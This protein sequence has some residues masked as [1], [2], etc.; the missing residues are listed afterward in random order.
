MR[1]VTHSAALAL[2]L[3]GCSTTPPPVDRP[4]DADPPL[5]TAKPVAKPAPVRTYADL[6]RAT[7][8]RMAARLNAPLYWAS[9]K[10]K[11]GSPDPDEIA[12]L[13]FFP[14]ATK[15][16]DDG[17]F[18]RAFDVY[19]ERLVQA[20]KAPAPTDP[21]E[22]LALKELDGAASV[23][24]WTDLRGATQETRDVVAHVLSVARG[25]DGLYAAQNGID[26][27]AGRIGVNDL[28]GQS[29]FRRNWGPSCSVPPLDQ[30]K[31]CSAIPGAP[32][33]P[34]DVYP[35]SLQI[36]DDWCKKLED[37]KD[38][39]TL[40]SPFTVVRE[41]DKKLIAVP[42]NQAYADGMKRVAND[43]RATA[44]VIHD[45]AE[46][47][48]K[49]YLEAA[50][51]S[52]DT[53]DWQPADEAWAKMNSRNSK[54]YL[55]VAPDE[56]YWEPC[57]QKAGF[58]VSFA[59]INTDSIALQDKL[60]PVQQDMEDTLAKLIGHPYVARKVTF[61]L[62][63]F[64]DIIANAGDARD[65]IGATIGQSLPN[66]GPVANEGRGRTVAMNNL[67]ADPDS[68][69]VRH[70]KAESLFDDATMKFYADD[71][72]A[73][74]LSTVLHEATHNLGP[75]HEYTY[76]GKKDDDAFGGNLASMLEELK[77]QSGAL[78]FLDVL[79][80]KG[81]FTP[82][83]VNRSYTDSMVWAVNHISRGMYTPTH[84][85]K[86]YSQLACIQVG[87]LIGEKA[88][89]W[90]PKAKSAGGEVGAF[91]IDYEKFPKAVEKLMKTVGNIKARGD[92]TLALDLAKKFVD[93]K[94][95]PQGVIAERLLRFPQPNFVYAVDAT[96]PKP[97]E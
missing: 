34:V 96:Q 60:T 19:Y 86:A 5:A 72:S 31:A 32:K 93:G 13:L 12:T 1:C 50:A 6:D 33:V 57:S 41:R 74:L 89:I 65:A 83:E 78:F 9:D 44:A 62:P 15:W 79:G 71:S 45:P 23:L 20:S 39:K 3:A 38:A 81:L 68:L 29:L 90:D 30:N 76:L 42:Y 46:A 35:A 97:A 70:K 85:R 52:F 69:A 92:K 47:A 59:F 8:N 11:N 16:V 18:T 43:L 82:A 77:A 73:G 48:F 21:R 66:W 27:F 55:R 80:K 87:F 56:T 91:H 4:L 95:V 64:I 28:I 88:L 40:F 54:Y 2:V 25:I 51:K 10:N 61:H 58:H 67:Y 37:D 14:T 26:A 17:A 7:F 53:N 84:Q 36:G 22:A 63:D 94:V 75:S 49:T 24:V